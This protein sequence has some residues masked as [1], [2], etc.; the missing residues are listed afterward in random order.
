MC[1]PILVHYYSQMLQDVRNVTLCMYVCT[2]VCRYVCVYVRVCV[3][4]YVC[5]CMYICTYI[6]VYVVYRRAYP[7]LK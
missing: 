2:C 7:S 3:C 6:P 5:M 4:V 1:F